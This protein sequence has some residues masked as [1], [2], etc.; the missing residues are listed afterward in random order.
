MEH[1]VGFKIYNG[2]NLVNISWRRG[3]RMPTGQLVFGDFFCHSLI[4]T[5]WLEDLQMFAIFSY[6]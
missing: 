3:M 6:K 5:H 2:V 4:A 1:K